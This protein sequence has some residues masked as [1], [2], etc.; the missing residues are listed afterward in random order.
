ML[1]V[2]ITMGSVADQAGSPCRAWHVTP[3]SELTAFLS[4]FVE[5]MLSATTRSTW[6]L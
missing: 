2:L 1:L 4:N 6:A 5:E 3:S